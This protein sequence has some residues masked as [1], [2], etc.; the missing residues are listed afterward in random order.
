[1]DDYEKLN[2]ELFQY[3]E[4]LKDKP[5]IIAANKAD[6][7]F[8]DEKMN[9]LKKS[10]ED[11]KRPFYVISA[12]T[13]TGI[14]EL[15]TAAGKMLK[16]EERRIEHEVASTEVVERIVKLPQKEVERFTVEKQEGIYVIEGDLVRKLIYSLNMESMDSLLHFYRVLEKHGVIEKLKEMGIQEGDVVQIMEVEFE[17]TEQMNPGI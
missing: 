3:A 17:F 12:A 2:Q 16:E 14:D 8:D 4:A 11:K 10:F 7:L 9:A 6:L 5:Q 15:M 1:M 13:G